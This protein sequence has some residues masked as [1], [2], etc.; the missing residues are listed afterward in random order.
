MNLKF[1]VILSVALFFSGSCLSSC[2]N[3]EAEH[4]EEEH[5][6]TEEE[7]EHSHT[8]AITLSHKQASE[9][10]VEVTPLSQQP[11]SEVIK[12]SGMIEPTASG[13]ATVTAKRSGIV[14]LNKNIA[15]GSQVKNGTL[16]ASISSRGL[17]GGDVNAVAIAT[18]DAAKRELDRLIPLHK[19]GLVTTAALNEAERNYKEAAAAVGTNG[20]GGSEYAAINGIVSAIF[21]STGDY[22]ETGAPIASVTADSRL[23]LRADVPQ[24]YAAAIPGIRTAHFRA[25]GMSEII[26]IEEHEGKPVASGNV[27]P[28]VNGYIPVYFTFTS[29]GDT[30]S[31][32]FAEV[33]LI[34]MPKGNVL[35]LPREALIEMQGNYYA[36][37]RLKGHEDAYEK[38]LVKTGTTDGLYFEIIEGVKPGE[39]VVTKG[40]TI[41]RMAE[42]TAIAPP[43]HSHNH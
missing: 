6:K 29:T 40:A 39:E 1:N 5:N 31:G 15:V 41:I 22:V 27:N 20:G 28:A 26:K 43:G 11:F 2:H 42:T 3:H 34:G 14:T 12:V 21:V 30:P 36:Y 35:S 38:R 25:D 19:D 37:V 4:S 23:T 9:F 33:Y 7:H 8:G 13:R 18:R 16:I 17:Q 10:G 24:R 32:S